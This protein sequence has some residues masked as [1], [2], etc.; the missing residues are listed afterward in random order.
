MSRP[1]LDDDDEAE[2]FSDVPVDES[3]LSESD[4]GLSFEFNEIFIFFF[5]LNLHVSFVLNGN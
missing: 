3:Y 2:L 4:L 5:K 1:K